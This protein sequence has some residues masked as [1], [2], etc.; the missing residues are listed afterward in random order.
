MLD[1]KEWPGLKTVAMIESRTEKPNGIFSSEQRYYITSLAMDVDKIARAIRGYW[2]VENSLH[3]V[4]NVQM[5]EDDSRIRSGNAAENMARIRRLMI[6]MQKGQEPRK[7]RTSIEK[8]RMSCI[9]SNDFLM[10]YSRIQC[11]LT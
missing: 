10:I 2:A 7:K 1:L 6:N 3:W 11:P 4:L 5:S 8:K 9:L